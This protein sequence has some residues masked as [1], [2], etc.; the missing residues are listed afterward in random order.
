[1]TEEFNKEKLQDLNWQF[2]QEDE[3]SYEKHI[4]GVSNYNDG[5]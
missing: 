2:P 5:F 3:I 1:M 4:V